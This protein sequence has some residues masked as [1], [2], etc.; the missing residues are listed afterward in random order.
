MS[1]TQIAEAQTAV[2]LVTESCPAL[3]GNREMILARVRIDLPDEA[4]SVQRYL[5]AVNRELVVVHCHI[6]RWV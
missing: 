6:T 1:T 2:E 3:R 4:D 5:D